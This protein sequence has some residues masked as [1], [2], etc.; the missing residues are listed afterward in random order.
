MLKEVQDD[1]HPSLNPRDVEYF[2]LW[3]MTSG[4]CFRIQYLVGS[5]LDTCT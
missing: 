5:T 2:A 4:V 3:E 1:G